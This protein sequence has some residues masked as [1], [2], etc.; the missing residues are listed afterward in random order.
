MSFLK[1]LT[2]VML[3]AVML[4]S[5]AGCGEKEDKSGNNKTNL[6][7]GDTIGDDQTLKENNMP[8][9]ATVSKILPRENNNCRVAGEYDTRF[10]SEEEII[11]LGDYAYALSTGDAE[12]FESVVHPDYVKNII[13]EGGYADTA[14]YLNK[15][16]ESIRDTYIGEEFEFD[17][18]LTT[19]CLVNEDN[20]FSSA[21]IVI[22]EALGDGFI[23]TVTTRKL[24]TLDLLY[25]LKESGGSY[26]LYNRQLAYMNLYIYEADGKLYIF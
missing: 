18:V 15:M 11:L 21:D 7:A 1:K 13:Q 23:D 5:V 19:N 16:Y 12:V 25:T 14:D 17:Y 2:A 24:V 26:S 20:D 22:A 4:A 10:L 8:Y 6:A 3:G 9:G